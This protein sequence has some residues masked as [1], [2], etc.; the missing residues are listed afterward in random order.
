MPSGVTGAPEPVD[1][2]L[3]LGG[4]CTPK[5]A[6]E[7]D[8]GDVSCDAN[9]AVGAQG[10]DDG[11]CVAVGRTQAG[12]TLVA[13]R[14]ACDPAAAESGCREGYS[15]GWGS[16]VCTEGC[17][18]DTECR[19]GALDTDDDGAPDMFGYDSGSTLTCD[20]A[21]ARCVHPAGPQA[22]GESCVRDQDCAEN[23]V[24]IFDGLSVAGHDFPAG[25][26]TREGCDFEANACDNGT[27]CL[28]L[29]PQLQANR[30]APLCL[31]E[32]TVGIEGADLRTGT[33]GHG[34]GCREGYR[35]HYNGGSGATSGVC[36]GG[37]YNAVTTNNVGA[38]CM[39]DA[40]CYSPF[41]LGA[42]LQFGSEADMLPGICTIFECG[43]PGLPTDLCG[44]KN[45]CISLPSRVA[46]DETWCIHQCADAK[47]CPKGF[48]C[49]DVDEDAD[50]P[51]NCIPQC[52]TDAD[53]K[54]G[55]K[56]INSAGG[57]GVCRL[58]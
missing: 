31:Q 10:C 18:N 23:G 41:G 33:A 37:N 38:E 17:Q 25:Y 12:G 24:C 4:S 40:D 13:C 29:R 6:T 49:V 55:E 50:T 22:S 20:P 35:C 36:V 54:T 57:G 9:A 27:V 43:S 16:E 5:R 47:D 28:S 39:A 8:G 48:G 2:I 46:T 45:E 30:Q 3:F 11:V 58:Q 52:E 44:E 56:C 34:Q 42:C 15:C 21:S 19:I 53:C 26:C 32:C 51:K 14:Q 7:Y 1:N